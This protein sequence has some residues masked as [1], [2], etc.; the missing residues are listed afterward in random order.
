M[1]RNFAASSIY[2]TQRLVAA[3][4]AIVFVPPSSAEP[5]DPILD[6]GFFAAGPK[7]DWPISAR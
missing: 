1:A 4:V 2:A 3:V 7:G 5:M 6:N